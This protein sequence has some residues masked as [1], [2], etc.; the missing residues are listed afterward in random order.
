MNDDTLRQHL[1]QART[2]A[3]VGLSTDPAKASHRVASYL[4]AQG[5]RIIPVHPRADELLGERVVRSLAEIAEPVDIVD[6]FRPGPETLRWAEEAI[7]N[8]AGLLWLQEGITSEETAARAEAAGL[9][10]VMDACLMV[11]HRRLL[12]KV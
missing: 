6:V 7:T 2:I 1:S 11:E 8:G 5:Y 10:W 9:P 3:V 4:Q 12:G